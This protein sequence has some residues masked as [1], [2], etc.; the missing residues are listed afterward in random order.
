MSTAI[1]AVNAAI[2][3]DS[4]EKATEALKAAIPIIDKTA[5]KG[6]IHRKNAARKVSK[7]TKHVNAFASS[8]QAEA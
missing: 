1:K 5:V 8:K 7:L 6:A 2:E 4:V 3:E